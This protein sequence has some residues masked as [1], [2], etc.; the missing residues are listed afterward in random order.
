M[1]GGDGRDHAGRMAEPSE[2]NLDGKIAIV[3]GATT[4]IGK[5]IARG[6]A[7]RGA[8]VVIG[9]RTFE[10]GD[11]ARRDIAESTGNPR[12]EVMRVDV[13]SIA[14][15]RGFVTTFCA[16]HD[17]LDILVNNAGIWVTER[18]ESPEGHELT[19]A[20][21]VLGPYLLT[22][23]LAGRLYAGE[24]ARV[25]NIVSGLAASYD[26]SDLEFTRRRFSGFDAYAQ[27]KAALRMLTWGLAGRFAGTGVTVNAA[28]PGFVKSELDRS[29]RGF[30][31]A[32]IGI[33]SRL[34]AVGPDKGADTPLFV[35]TA[36]ELERVSG[37]FFDGRK[38]KEGKFED[39]AAIAELERIC[40]E[41]S[42][43]PPLDPSSMPTLRPRAVG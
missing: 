11:L 30:M 18:S 41:M 6:L 22:T 37:A 14:S 32:I 39:V 40:G 23:L 29:A 12:I 26:A 31:A 34:F 4:G 43:T 5:E 35:A 28:A 15:V 27:S 3:T 25:V 21:N 17:R 2:A 9:A 36:A 19:F 20:T 33:S 13:A 1:V 38:R 42:G 16:A 7:A 10:R 8:R 24:S